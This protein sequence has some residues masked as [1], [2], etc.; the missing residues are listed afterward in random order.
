MSATSAPE[1][2]R[3][4]K[5]KCAASAP[6]S[7]GEAAAGPPRTTIDAASSP[8]LNDFVRRLRGLDGVSNAA[9]AV[10]KDDSKRASHLGHGE[11]ADGGPAHMQ[12]ERLVRV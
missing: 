10:P 6:G 12:L 8:A 3:E 2:S 11:S 7:S 4:G 1:P 5:D 9:L